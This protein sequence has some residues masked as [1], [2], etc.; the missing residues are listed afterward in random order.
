[1]HLLRTKTCLIRREA[2]RR[3]VSL[4][5]CGVILFSLPSAAQYNPY[6]KVEMNRVDQDSKPYYFGMSLGI[7][8]ARFQ[9]ELHPYFLQHDTVMVAEPVNSG[10]INLGFQD[11]RALAGVL[12]ALPEWR[13]PG[14]LGVLRRYARERAEEP[15]L[16]QYTTHALN[17]LFNNRNPVLAAVRNVGLNLTNALPVV[18]NA[19]IRYAVNG[20]F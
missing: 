18:R 16:M 19:L 1:M 11:A 15:L 12:G 10:G 14:E 8:L 20:R 6:S 7:N 17:R 13:D 4:M 3:T 2:F 5:L 9:T